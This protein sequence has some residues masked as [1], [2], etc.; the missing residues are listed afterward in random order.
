MDAWHQTQ[1]CTASEHH[2]MARTGDLHKKSSMCG[3][4]SHLG[5]CENLGDGPHTRKGMRLVRAAANFP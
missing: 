4:L 5:L 3:L 2:L 1:P